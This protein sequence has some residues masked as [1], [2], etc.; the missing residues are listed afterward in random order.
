MWSFFVCARVTHGAG[1]NAVSA[2]FA[3]NI[4]KGGFFIMSREEVFPMAH[5]RAFSY[6]TNGG[7]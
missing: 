7:Y 3:I 4:E 2:P 5:L 6:K 1:N